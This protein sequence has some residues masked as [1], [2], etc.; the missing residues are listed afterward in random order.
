MAE[1]VSFMKQL[2]SC[3]VH[4][5]KLSDFPLNDLTPE[6][7]YY[8]DG[9]ENGFEG[10]PDE[11]KE[12]PPPTPES[13]ENYVGSRLQLPRGQ[14]LVQGRVLKRARDNDNNVIKKKIRKFG[15]MADASVEL[16]HKKH[17]LGH[18]YRVGLLFGGPRSHS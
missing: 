12:A 14:G 10:T 6:F 9:I 3:I 7:E 16:L 11:I 2:N 13:S 1:R 18:S 4:A 8:A 5:A 15:R 17:T